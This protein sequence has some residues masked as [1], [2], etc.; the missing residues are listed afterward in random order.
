MNTIREITSNDGDVWSLVVD[1]EDL[2]MMHVFD[3]ESKRST[4]P[5]NALVL[6]L[7]AIAARNHTP[8]HA[9]GQT[10]IPLRHPA[11]V[12]FPRRAVQ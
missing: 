2:K 3:N 8:I 5:V 1:G 9:R 12:D 4:M 10:V 6:E 11:V 7:F